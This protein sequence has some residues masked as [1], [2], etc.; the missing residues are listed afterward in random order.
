MCES[1]QLAHASLRFKVLGP[2]E[3]HSDG[4]LLQPGPYKQ[5]VLLGALLC[6]ANTVIPFD[7]L[8]ELIWDGHRPRTARKNLHAYVSSLRKIIGSRIS[9]WNQGYRL[10]A[11]ADELDLLRF[12]KLAAAGRAA[13]RGGDLEGGRLLLG[14]SV[15]LWRDRALVDLAG[16]A[17]IA[18][19]SDR[20]RNRY[21][22]AYEDWAELEI[23]AGNLDALD[24]LSELAAEHPFRERLVGATMTFLDKSGSRREALAYYESH[25]Q[26]MARELGLDPSPV[27]QDLYKS[28]IV[29]WRRP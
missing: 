4:V 18:D 10:Q 5:R 27:L 20:L 16:N 22:A 21:L 1:S 3:V 11:D 29:A 12:D 28:I 2:L 7:Q 24:R 19:E 13:R 15:R 26:V 17:F 14:E 23:L 9:F 8:L 25:R 6:R